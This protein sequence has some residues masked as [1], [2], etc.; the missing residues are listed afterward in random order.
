MKYVQ[1][2]TFFIPPLLRVEVPV[3]ENFSH[4]SF[5]AIEAISTSV[6]SVLSVVHIAVSPI[7][8]KLL[9]TVL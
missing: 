8:L 6:I 7:S 1:L 2:T 4:N 9:A 5:S 3:T